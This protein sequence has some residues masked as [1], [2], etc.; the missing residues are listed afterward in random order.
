MVGNI[1]S[2]E[3]VVP[4]LSQVQARKPEAI[5]VRIQRRCGPG[6]Q[7]TLENLPEGLVVRLDDGFLT[8]ESLRQ[9]LLAS[10]IVVMSYLAASQSGIF[11]NCARSG[12]ISLVTPVGEAAERLKTTGLGQL[13][14]S[15]DQLQSF[16]EACAYV[17]AQHLEVNR[18]LRRLREVCLFTLETL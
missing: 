12:C 3:G 17:E 2:Y 5:E 11:Y 16:L 13:C 8:S 18:R 9:A 6:H 4:C 1:K 10:P 15:I 14:F 7:P